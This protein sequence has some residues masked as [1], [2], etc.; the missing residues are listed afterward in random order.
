[1]DVNPLFHEIRRATEK[2]IV[3]QGGTSSGKTYEALDNILI[4]SIEK[5]NIIT[6]VVAEDVPTLKRGALRDCLTIINNNPEIKQHVRDYNK[7]DRIITLDTGSLIEF[8][9]YESFQDAK[10]GKRDIL[11]INEA[12]SID[13]EVY[14]QLAI[15][16]RLK[17]IVDYNPTVSFWV[18]EKLIGKPGA[19][20]IISDHRHNKFLSKEQHE[21]I[22]SIGDPELWKVYARGRTGRLSATVFSWSNIPVDQFPTDYD[23]LIW[24]IDY[25]YGDKESSGKT[26]ITKIGVN[27]KKDVYIRE[28]CYHVG[29][30]DEYQI[31]EVLEANGWVNGQPFYSEHD[32]EAMQG[33]RKLGIYVLTARKGPRCEWHAIQKIKKLNVHYTASD[34]NMHEEVVKYRFVTVGD[35]VT[36]T[37]KDTNQFHLMAATRYG[38]YSHYFYDI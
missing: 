10:A 19:K 28:C 37:V 26:A 36:N 21:E 15:R 20:L 32:Q 25:G 30:M 6:T 5:S 8:N 35:I 29:G 9:S 13:Y 3:L 14:W 1:M 22:E 12:D 23:E 2:V 4:W 33:L 34:N 11:F 17:I 24:S 27:K 38:L 18:H 16:T 31:K 7:S